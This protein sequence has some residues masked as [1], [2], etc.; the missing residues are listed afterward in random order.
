[1]FGLEVDNGFLGLFRRR[2]TR[3]H[4]AELGGELLGF[5]GKFVQGIRYFTAAHQNGYAGIIGA[6]VFR[7]DYFARDV[8]PPVFLLEQVFLG[9][10]LLG[11]GLGF[12]L[13]L[14]L[15]HTLQFGRQTL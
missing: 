15:G 3:G 11:R 9:G 5:G 2:V 10:N 14:R 6:H 7:D 12:R 8:L 1:M 4:F 13:G